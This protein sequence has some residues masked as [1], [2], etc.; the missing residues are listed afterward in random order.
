MIFVAGD[1]WFIAV[2]YIN[3]VKLWKIINQRKRRDVNPIGQP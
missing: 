2:K 1:Y 3:R